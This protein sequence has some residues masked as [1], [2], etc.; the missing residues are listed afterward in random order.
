MAVAET[1]RPTGQEVL[2]NPILR[3]MTPLGEISYDRESRSAL[4]PLVGEPVELTP[5]EGVIF[6][7]LMTQPE[8]TITYREVGQSLYGIQQVDHADIHSIHVHILR[9]RLKLGDKIVSGKASNAL[10]QLIHYVPNVGYSLTD[11][12]LGWEQF[13]SKEIL[14]CETPAGELRLCLPE[15][16]VSSPLLARKVQLAPV[17]FALLKNLASEPY[18]IHEYSE[19]LT[20]VWNV[21]EV[22]RVTIHMII[23]RVFSLRNKLGDDGQEPRLVYTTPGVG[24]SLTPIDNHK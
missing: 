9:L 18:R 10:F 11:P 16:A 5:T 20:A 2:Q 23:Q 19:L 12:A 15:M 8:S 13:K 3:V 22:S 24:L 21:N 7:A 1:L 17:D 4:S 14:T 6:D